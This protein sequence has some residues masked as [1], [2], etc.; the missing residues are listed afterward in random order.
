MISQITK[1]A[2]IV[3]VLTILA[4]LLALSGVF[5]TELSWFTLSD[6]ASMLSAFGT[7]FNVAIGFTAPI[8]DWHFVSHLAGLGFIAMLFGFGYKIVLFVVKRWEQL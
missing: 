8:I 1:W 5:P 7:M 6:F 2:L 4:N 3:A